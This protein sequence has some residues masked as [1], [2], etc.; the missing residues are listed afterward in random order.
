[1]KYPTMAR[2]E[3]ASRVQLARWYRHLPSPGTSAIG[4]DKFNII[5]HKEQMIMQRI[6]N[7]FS[8]LGGMTP[9]IS[10]EIGW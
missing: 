6:W 7:R 1:M 5:M 4:T 9:A 8:A 2:V 3:E 10:K